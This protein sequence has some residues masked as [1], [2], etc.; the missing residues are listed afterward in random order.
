ML[1]TAVAFAYIANE[2]LSSVENLGEM[3]ILVP[4][5]IVKYLKQIKYKGEKVDEGGEN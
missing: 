4:E 3:G 1:Q 5:P 2:G